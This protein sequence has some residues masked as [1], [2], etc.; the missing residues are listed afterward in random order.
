MK[1]IIFRELI[2]DCLFFF[3]L[4]LFGISA[5]IWVFQAVNFLD[6]MIEDGRKIFILGEGRLI[7]LSAAEGHPPSV[8]DMSFANQALASE[9]I[10]KNHK[11]FKNEVYTLPKSVDQEIAALKIR[12][13][14]KNF[15]KLK[16]KQEKYLNSWELGTGSSQEGLE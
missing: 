14:G 1:K 9:Y 2:S 12:S 7:N 15:D 13:F 6:I 11:G 5:I 4:S 16:A 8:M 3:L 10:V